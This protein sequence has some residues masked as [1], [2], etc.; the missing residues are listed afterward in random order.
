MRLTAPADKRIF[1]V[2]QYLKF[3]NLEKSKI[4]S[5]RWNRVHR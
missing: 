5:R 2:K 3:L 1:F 4:N